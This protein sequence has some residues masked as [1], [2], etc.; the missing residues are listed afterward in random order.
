MC[1]SSK[2]GDFLNTCKEIILEFNDKVRRNDGN[3][4]L[5][6]M[7][8]YMKKKMEKNEK[9]NWIWNDFDK[10][11]DIMLA[12]RQS[13]K[14]IAKI[15]VELTSRTESVNVLRA[16]QSNLKRDGVNIIDRVPGTFVEADP[17]ERYSKS[18]VAGM[19]SEKFKQKILTDNQNYY[20]SLMGVHTRIVDPLQKRIKELKQGIIANEMKVKQVLLILL[21]N[22]PMAL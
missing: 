7:A 17:D 19:Y 5:N 15:E 3:Q 9:E 6:S 11:F 18:N 8:A 4:V 21:A 13:K 16:C 2:T 10:R 12:I 14:E 22:P 20:E 1:P